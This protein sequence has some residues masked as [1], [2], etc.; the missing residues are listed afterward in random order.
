[1]KPKKPTYAARLRA[2]V[3]ENVSLR[4]RVGALTD[5]SVRL[6]AERETLRQEYIKTI[7]ERDGLHSRAIHQAEGTIAR[8]VKHQGD[9]ESA[10]A[11]RIAPETVRRAQAELERLQ[12]LEAAGT[13]GG[14][15]M[16]ALRLAK[17]ALQ[18]ASTRMGA[19]EML[20]TDIDL[21]HRAMVLVTDS[22][23]GE[24]T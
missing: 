20:G 7:A 13:I 14:A 3:A 5:G 10:V 16:R 22:L 19:A 15:P 4:A 11:T 6:V 9:L 21:V 8:L 1:M 18:T 23:D 2:A 24:P 12:R 17:A